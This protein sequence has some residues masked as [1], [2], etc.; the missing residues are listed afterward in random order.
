MTLSHLHLVLNHF[1]IVAIIT[2][3]LFY[4]MGIFKSN[5][6]LKRSALY[7]AIGAALFAIPTF[8]T[9]EDAEGA[10]LKVLGTSKDMIHEHE[11]AGEGGAGLATALNGHEAYL[12]TN[13]GGRTSP[14]RAARACRMSDARRQG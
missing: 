5:D 4:L 14:R 11:E 9:G 8:Y 2:A 12:R 7:I 6:S 3:T 1:P 13:P 10:A